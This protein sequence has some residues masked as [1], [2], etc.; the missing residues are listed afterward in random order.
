ML[1]GAVAVAIIAF[2]KQV[3]ARF[4]IDDWQTSSKVTAEYKWTQKPV[5]ADDQF[6]F[7]T[8][9]PARA[10]LHITGCNILHSISR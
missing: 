7:A 3:A 8:A 6:R 10:D 9:L 1:I 4:T 5:D 2:E